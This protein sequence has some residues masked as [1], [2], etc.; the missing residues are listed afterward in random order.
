M[1]LEAKI[2][3]MEVEGSMKKSLAEYI[4]A[5]IDDSTL[6]KVKEVVSSCLD[7]ITNLDNYQIKATVDG[8]K[9]YCDLLL[10]VPVEH[11]HE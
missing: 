3:L 1:N 10:W 4:G 6:S 7:G 11:I 9:I 2:R 5:S 8:D